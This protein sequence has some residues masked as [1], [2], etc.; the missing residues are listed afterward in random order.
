MANLNETPTDAPDEPTQMVPLPDDPEATTETPET[1]EPAAPDST[2]TPPSDIPAVAPTAAE[3]QAPDP[4]LV[5]RE[6]AVTQAQEAVTQREQAAATQQAE[7]EHTRQLTQVEN[8]LRTRTAELERT[9]LQPE[10]ISAIV[11]RERGL[12]MQV[13]E[14]QQSAQQQSQMLRG[15]H[16]AALKYSEQYGIPFNDIASMATPQEMEAAGKAFEANKTSSGE[17]A[18]LRA[19]VAELKQDKVPADQTFDDGGGSSPEGRDRAS[20]LDYLNDKEG[21]HTDAEW[22]ELSKLMANT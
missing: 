10:Q 13:L 20:R 18:K 3:P 14:A 22:E 15:Q 21:P 6:A 8:D 2:D 11:D 9:G 5:E 7:F 4:A 16:N 17:V 19:E 1:N 12:Q